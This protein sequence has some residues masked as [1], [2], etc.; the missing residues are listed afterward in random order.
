[1]TGLA[2]VA[3]MGV[4]AAAG[5]LEYWHLVLSGVISGLLVGVMMPARQA[6]VHEVVRGERL[7]NAVSLNTGAMNITQILAPAAGGFLLEAIGAAGTFFT[8]AGCYGFAVLTM[9]FVP[10]VRPAHTEGPRL[11]SLEGFRRGFRD[12]ADGVAYVRHHPQIRMVLILS[13]FVALLGSAYMP[14]LPGFVADVFDEGAGT[15]GVL[16]S[17]SAAGSLVGALVLASLPDRRRGLLLVASA[18]TLG[19]G[20]LAFSQSGVVLIAAVCMIVV[21]VGQAGRQSIANTLLQAH[22]EDAYRGRVM[23]L[24]MT[25]FSMMSLGAF[26]IGVIAG[27]V[28]VQWAFAGMAAGLVVV[29][30]ASLVLLPGL[31]RID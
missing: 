26:A 16:T 4:L 30:G 15:I 24:F 2:N 28:G 31:R 11:L 21:G 23:A 7:M 22:S 19:G 17:V 5:V 27:A 25:Q 9:A 1:V 20:L 13:F 29:S 8:M 10:A 3:L 6:M 18:L 14:I 12:I